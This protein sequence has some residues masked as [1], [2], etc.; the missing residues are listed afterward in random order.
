MNV[1]RYI[2]FQK[3]A[4]GYYIDRGHPLAAGVVAH[5]L[6]AEGGGGVVSDVA[7]GYHASGGGGL[8]WASSFGP[9]SGP[10]GSFNGTTQFIQTPPFGIPLN[11]YLSL[12]CWFNQTAG[13]GRQT[14]LGNNNTT[15]MPQIE[16]NIN[17]V[18]GAIG[19]LK[20]GVFMGSTSGSAYAQNTW[21]HFV[22]SKNGL[23]DPSVKGG[24]SQSGRIWLNGVP[25]PVVTGTGALFADTVCNWL[26][27]ERAASSQLFTGRIG[28]I[29][30]RN[31]ILTDGEVSQLYAEPFAFMQAPPSRRWFS[32]TSSGATFA[33]PQLGTVGVESDAFTITLASPSAGTT[34]VNLAS[35]G[36]GDVFHATSG[37]PSVA[38]IAIGTGQTTGTFYL[39]PGTRGTRTIT[40]TVTGVTISPATMSYMSGPATAN[41][42]GSNTGAVSTESGAIIITLDTPAPSGGI[43]IALASSDASDAFHATPG[44]SVVTSIAIAAGQ[45]E[46]TFYVAASSTPGTHVITP[47]ATGITFSPSA[48]AY[49]ATAATLTCGPTSSVSDT[50]ARISFRTSMDTTVQIKYSTAS[51]LSNATTTGNVSVNSST[52]WTGKIDLSGLSPDTP[53]Y[54]TVLLAGVDQL[55]APYATLRTFPASGSAVSFSFAFGSCHANTSAHVYNAGSGGDPDTIFA[56]LPAAARFLIHLGDTIYADQDN[57]TGFT[58]SDYRAHHQVAM[59]GASSFTSGWAAWRRKSPIFVTWDDH[60]IADNYSGGSASLDISKYAPAKQSFQEYHG[61]ANPDGPTPGELYYSFEYGNVGFFVLDGRSF[62]S[63]DNAT[64]NSSKTLL[65]PVQLAA[66][67]SWLSSNNAKYRIKFVCTGTTA[68]GYGSNTTTDSWGGQYDGFQT[69]QGNNNGFR[70]ERNALWDWIDSNNIVGVVFL[71]GDMHWGGAFKTAYGTVVGSRPRYEFLASPF[72][73]AILP[74]PSSVT[75]DLVNGPVFFTYTQPNA[76]VV[77]VDTTT[78]PAT[79]SFQLY[80]RSGSLGSNYATSINSEAIDASLSFFVGSSAV[81][82]RA[83][84]S[85]TGTFS[86]LSFAGS[87]V[88]SRHPGVFATGGYTSTFLGSCSVSTGISSVMTGVRTPP[89]FAGTCSVSTGISS[90]MTGVRNQ[91]TFAGTCSVST[92]ISS[93]MTGV[94]TPPTFAGTSAV[95]VSPIVATSGAIGNLGLFT[96]TTSLVILPRVATTGR[97]VIATPTPTTTTPTTPIIQQIQV[98]DAGLDFRAVVRNADGPID[99]SLATVVQFHFQKPDGSF[100]SVAAMLPNSG[101]DGVTSYV[102]GPTDFDQDGTWRHQVYYEIGPLRV[103]S[104]ITKFKVYPN[105]PLES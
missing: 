83:T 31:R 15:G 47:T 81:S 43:T 5:W 27:G 61:R 57:V 10:T 101:S 46:G 22:Y 16:C 99:L 23:N 41:I 17:G 68:S 44:G 89:T 26:I 1:T 37:G 24:I 74:P 67:K 18:L 20:S 65:G 72:N 25:M 91:P 69:P 87:C 90:A 13:T 14:I 102:T 19:V 86:A 78:S 98:G 21:N 36:T 9:Y 29:T 84:V 80:S 82:G 60:E 2:R 6:F 76:G 95:R 73:Q 45:T 30:I 40:P 55:T 56:A 71:A 85:G 59:S 48:W 100:L 105:L 93:A 70:T 97:M 38:S 7:G 49:A 33:G 88:L 42:S 34:T 58:L 52:D 11:N 51:D 28:E 3:P 94:R 50:T 77:T 75:P 66:L 8:S 79:V 103:Y 4:V 104:N 64:D 53:Y 92:G 32:M 12:S 39:V 35:T 54:Y 63:F 62:R 96:G